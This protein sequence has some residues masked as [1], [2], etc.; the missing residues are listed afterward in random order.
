MAE[1]GL[2]VD[3]VTIWHWVQRYAPILNQRLRRE[4]RHANRSWRVDENLRLSSWK[5][6]ISVSRR[7][8]GRG[9]HRFH[10]VAQPGFGSS[11][12][13]LAIGVA[14]N[15]APAASDQRGRPSSLCRRDLGIETVR[16][17]GTAVPMP[18]ITI[19]A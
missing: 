13:F 14:P 18:A 2:A 10:A 4:R 7:E 15:G 11:E 12:A 19:H 5:L 8:F 9:H 6:G 3:Q 1:R 16:R 17:I